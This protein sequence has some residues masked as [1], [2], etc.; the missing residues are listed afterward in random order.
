MEVSFLSG[1]C[2]MPLSQM[3]KPSRQKISKNRA[4]L[5][6][7]MYQ[8][9]MISIYRPHH[10]TREYTFFSILDGTFTSNRASTGFSTLNGCL[11]HWHLRAEAEFK[12]KCS[13]D[14]GTCLFNWESSRQQSEY[15]GPCYSQVRPR[16]NSWFLALA[17][18]IPG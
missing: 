18:P 13:S 15:V 8:L 7:T 17:W 1:D 2:N 6:S 12:Y 14:P 10:P 5:S 16:W 4:G 11:Q 3:D 9:D